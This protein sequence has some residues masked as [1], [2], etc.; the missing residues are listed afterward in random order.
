MEK[1]FASNYL[2][3]FGILLTVIGIPTLLLDKSAG[4][5]LP[6]LFG[7]FFIFI[8]KEKSED[9]RSNSLRVGSM[10]IAFLVAFLA[11]H[12]TKYFFEKGVIGWRLTEINH[13]S[14]LVFALAVSIF[15]SRL[16][17]NKV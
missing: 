17:L 13:F 12:L 11:A 1:L 5:E 4:S 8:S 14:I 6:L 7:L 3:Y 15:Y 2:K 9:E 16:Y 10:T